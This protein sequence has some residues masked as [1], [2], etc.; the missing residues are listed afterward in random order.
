MKYFTLG[1]DAFDYLTISSSRIGVGMYLRNCS[2]LSSHKVNDV[3]VVYIKMSCLVSINQ[4]RQS[5]HTASIL[6]S[7]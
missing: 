1:K 4:F 2:V 3:K 7:Q 6:K 5:D